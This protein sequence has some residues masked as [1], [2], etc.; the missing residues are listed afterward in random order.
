MRLEDVRSLSMWS[1]IVHL[2][3]AE[4]AVSEREK[5]SGLDVDLDSPLQI[6][7]FRLHFFLMF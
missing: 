4:E 3:C 5:V 1:G 2:F 6:V 7:N